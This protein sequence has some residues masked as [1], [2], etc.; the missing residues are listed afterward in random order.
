[1]FGNEVAHRQLSLNI[2]QGRHR[3]HPSGLA[4][5]A[6]RREAHFV[7]LEGVLWAR[8]SAHVYNEIGDYPRLAEALP[9]VLAEQPWLAEG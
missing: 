2:G 4:V 1:L 8:I 6:W 9:G 3:R 7:A 5:P